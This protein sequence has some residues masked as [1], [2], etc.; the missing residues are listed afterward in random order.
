MKKGRVTPEIAEDI[1][2]SWEKIRKM[3]IEGSGTGLIAFKTDNDISWVRKVVKGKGSKLLD[4]C[5]YED[6]RD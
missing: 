4:S 3:Y 2:K 5:G 6:L 1:K